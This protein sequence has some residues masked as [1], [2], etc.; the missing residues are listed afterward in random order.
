MSA[1]SIHIGSCVNQHPHHLVVTSGRCRLQCIAIIF[2]LS[3]Q[4]VGSI[5]ALVFGPTLTTDA[6]VFSLSPRHPG[7]PDGRLTG[8]SV[9]ALS[10][11]ARTG[12]ECGIDVRQN[13][14]PP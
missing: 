7:S 10:S 9:A 5:S 6:I 3:I 12:G 8:V 1:L 13:L 11:P 14:L 4:M 2:A